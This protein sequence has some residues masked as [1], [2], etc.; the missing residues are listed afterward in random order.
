MTTGRINQVTKSFRP[1]QRGL[2]RIDEHASETMK[3]RPEGG[4]S[5]VFFNES[6]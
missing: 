6:V 1:H 3:N 2:G 4:P 5:T